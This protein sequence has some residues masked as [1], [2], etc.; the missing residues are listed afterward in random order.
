[1]EQWASHPSKS[2]TGCVVDATR[3]EDHKNSKH[4]RGY[5]IRYPVMFFKSGVVSTKSELETEIQLY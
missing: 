5:H 2:R 1:M 4:T 3:G